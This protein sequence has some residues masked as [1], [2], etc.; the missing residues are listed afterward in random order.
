MLA[1]QMPGATVNL[2]ASLNA[3]ITALLAL[4]AKIELKISAVA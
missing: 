2:Q 3:E 4:I 1:L